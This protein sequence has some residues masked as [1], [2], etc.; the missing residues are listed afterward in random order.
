M[1]WNLFSGEPGGGEGSPDDA[2]D[3]DCFRN[4][5]LGDSTVRV[6]GVERSLSREGTRKESGTRSAAAV[7]A[8]GNE[9][10]RSDRSDDDRRSGRRGDAAP[11]SRSRSQ[12]KSSGSD[13]DA[14]S[15]SPRPGESVTPPGRDRNSRY[16][17]PSR[18]STRRRSK[19]RKRSSK[20]PTSSLG[21]A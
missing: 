7:D 10:G 20:Q 4:I 5:A 2:N 15:R 1:L 9:R 3:N 12:G 18:G 14:R 6:N 21:R 8:S 13:A 19:S 11:R 17:S 16:R